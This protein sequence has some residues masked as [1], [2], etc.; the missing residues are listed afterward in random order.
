MKMP[1]IIYLEKVNKE[2]AQ[3]NKFPQINASYSTSTGCNAIL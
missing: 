1:H 3:N 2:M